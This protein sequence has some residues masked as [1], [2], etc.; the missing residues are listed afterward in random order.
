ME[1]PQQQPP[2]HDVEAR[3]PQQQE[4]AAAA[5]LVDQLLC[6][7][8][9]D[10]GAQVAT[11]GGNS[12]GKGPSLLEVHADNHHRRAQDHS[13][14]KT[15]TWSGNDMR[16]RDKRMKKKKPTKDYKSKQEKLF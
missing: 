8:R 6:K 11:Q 9:H 16:N 10:G 15:C 2:D 14:R 7:D 3:A 5:V 4:G 1:G 12:W 13:E